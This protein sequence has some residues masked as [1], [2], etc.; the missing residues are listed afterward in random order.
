MEAGHGPATVVFETHIKPYNEP[1][2]STQ[3]SLNCFLFFQVQ[4]KNPDLRQMLKQ[5]SLP[6]LGFKVILPSFM[7]KYKVKMYFS[8]PHCSEELLFRNIG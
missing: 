4:H 1:L 8:W 7:M 3:L 6:W 5:F 2:A